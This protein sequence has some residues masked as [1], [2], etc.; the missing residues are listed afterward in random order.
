MNPSAVETLLL[1]LR[2]VVQVAPGEWAADCPV[3][4]EGPAQ[5]IIRDAEGDVDYTCD[6]G[7]TEAPPTRLGL[8]P[9]SV[10]LAEPIP[11][12]EWLLAPYLEA[13]SLA[14]IAS[15]PNLGKTLLAFWMAT[16]IAAGGK[17]VAIIEEEGGK[18]GFKLRVSRAVHAVGT[19]RCAFLAYTFKPR[20]SLMSEDDIIALCDELRGYHCVVIDSLGRTTPGVEENDA[21]EI[22]LLINNLDRIREATGCTLLL[23]HHTVKSKWKPGEVP[24]LEDCRGSSAFAAGIDTGIGLAPV[25][26]KEP[27]VVQFQLHITKQRD[28]DNQVPVQHVRIA[29]TGPEAHVDMEDVEA[30]AQAATP[31]QVAV[32]SLLPIVFSYI[33]DTPVTR[34]E[35]QK[36]IGR[37]AAHVRQSIDK[38]IDTGKVQD[39]GR[40]AG[41]VRTR[42]V[43]T[44][45]A[46]GQP[47]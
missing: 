19:E 7:C 25:E 20:I 12:T 21:K 22:G 9:V 45:G 42:H 29:M 47:D 4:H 30:P 44:G 34:E 43:F 46:H 38:L 27:G 41:L 40:K 10:L 18:R 26:E 16:Q 14:C 31:T 28:E 39:L 32:A 17:R 15:P 6:L 3:R 35:L 24:R 37:R 13:N 2:H 1:R 5:A 11:P 36:K 33:S 23:I 8:Q